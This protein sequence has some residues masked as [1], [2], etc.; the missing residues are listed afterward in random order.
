MTETEPPR[1]LS[2]ASVVP[3]LVWF[4]GPVVA[5]CIGFSEGSKWDEVTA[6]ASQV[7]ADSVAL[8]LGGLTLVFAPLVG[9]V[10]ALRRRRT[11]TI[12][13]Y[14]A[15][16]ALSVAAVIAVGA[17]PSGFVETVRQLITG[18]RPPSRAGA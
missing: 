6:T 7:R 12:V 3:L 17:T 8:L 4:I 1:R 5:A 9:L 2:P 18:D 15:V 14:G 13:L 11:V 10:L 16:F